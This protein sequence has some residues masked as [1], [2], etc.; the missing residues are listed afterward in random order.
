MFQVPEKLRI[1][2]D[3]GH[4]LYSNKNDGN[5]GVFG[6]SHVQGNLFAIASDG[7]GWEHVSVTR[8]DPKKIPTWKQMCFVKDLF[9][10]DDD[11]V[12]QY[13]PPK[14]QY[15]NNHPGC[16]HLWRQINI[17]FPQP[18]SILVGIKTDGI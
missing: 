16:L 8:C 1:I 6:I 3:P 13:H 11:C 5:N 12:I 17:Q 14:K 4:P 15:I 10:D 7:E 18:P 9:W 2:F